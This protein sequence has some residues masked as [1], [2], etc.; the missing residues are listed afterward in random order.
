[1]FEQACRADLEGIISKRVDA[2]YRPG[3]GGDWVKVKCLREQEFVIVGYTDPSGSRSGL[4]ALLLAVNGGDGLEFCGKVGTG[5]ST[6]VLLDL[7]RRLSK[8][9][10]SKPTVVNPPRGADARG[11][12]WVAPKLVAQIAYT[13]RT[14]D[15]ILRHPVYR[16][17]REDKEPHQVRWEKPVA[18]PGDAEMKKT[19]K[20]A[21]AK[22]AKAKTAKT[23]KKAGKANT[24]SSDGAI[25]VDGVRLTSPDKILYPEQGTTKED[26][27]AYYVAIQDW[28]LPH[29]EDRPL[30]LV[31][32]PQGRGKQCFFQKHMDEL[33]SPFIEKIRVK[34]E[35]AARDYG[36][37][38]S[39][40][41]LL[42]LVQLGA[43]ELHTWN[44]RADKLEKPDRFIIDLDPDEGLSWELVIDAAREVRALLEELGLQSFAKTTGGKGFHIVVP[45]QRRGE[46]AEV[47][48]FS[49]AV[50]AAIAAASPDRYT[51]DVSKAKRKGRLLLDYLRNTR[52]AT[53][54]EVFSTRARMGAT[55]SAPVT[56]DELEAGIRSD[57]FNIY[58][59]PERLKKLKQDPWKEYGT[60]KQSI[61]VP[62]KKRLGM[63]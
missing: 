26:L 44:S 25:E 21:K 32:C 8:L 33:D 35:K 7:K 9:E 58:N 4:G 39:V 30:T 63:K 59:L 45:I 36:T 40:Q 56:W 50:A 61:T 38:D 18:R 5:F 37:L 48:D 20:S 28:I 53:A 19:A 10:R 14:A 27:A 55:V 29:I 2:P 51:L 16:G 13:E 49:R 23:E 52:G 11:V 46:W 54:V 41:G 57:A 17:L 47:R 1:M 6:D 34:E 12:H 24:S 60:V 3:R 31:R 62:M 15:G 22:P 42:T 43:L